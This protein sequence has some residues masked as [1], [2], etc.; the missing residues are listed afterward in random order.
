MALMTHA[1][2]A[3]GDAALAGRIRPLIA[4]YRRQFVDNASTFF[5]SVEHYY[6]LASYTMGDE[7]SAVSAFDAA[8]HEHTRLDSPPLIALTK[9]ELGRALVGRSPSKDARARVLLAEAVAAADSLGYRAISRRGRRLLAP[10][11]RGPV[12]DGKQAG[13]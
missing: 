13:Q 6:A 2:A 8:L 12:A 5:G 3:V 1:A 9:L 4:P 11:G 10:S 7:A